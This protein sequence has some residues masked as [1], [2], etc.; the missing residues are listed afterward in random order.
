MIALILAIAGAWVLIEVG[1]FV[2]ALIILGIASARRERR[3]AEYWRKLQQPEPS[4][5]VADGEPLDDRGKPY[6]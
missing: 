2:L 3:D 6:R 5:R 1:S 4:P